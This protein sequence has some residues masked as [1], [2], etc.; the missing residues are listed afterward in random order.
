MAFPDDLLEQA[1]H[2]ANRERK[3]PRQ[4][5]LRRA[6]STAY[7]AIFHLLINEA[8]SKWKIGT[9]RA[10]LART[11]EHARM[12]SASDRIRN[13]GPKYF[14]DQNPETVSQLK[15]IATAFAEL[16]EYRQT[17]DYD[18]TTQ[19][20]R[21]DVLEIIETVRNAFKSVDATRNQRI[22]NDYLLS[23]F[24]KERK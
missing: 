11:F 24:V 23:L 9:Q 22:A 19:W 5:S 2:L 16:Y 15:L 14:R 20:A 7:Y 10:Q 17:A 3:R 8:V 1:Q 13:T 18:N 6:V 4:A 21:T 12:Y